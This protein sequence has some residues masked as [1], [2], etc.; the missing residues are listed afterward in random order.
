MRPIALGRRNSLVQRQ[1][2]VAP[3]AGSIRR[4]SLNHRKA[5]RSRS[6]GHLP[7]CLEL[8]VHPGNQA[9]SVHELLPLELKTGPRAHRA[10]CR[11]KPASR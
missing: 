3:R 6:A 8:I 2:R 10:M 9:P 1:P 5:P 11:M 7:T 4:R